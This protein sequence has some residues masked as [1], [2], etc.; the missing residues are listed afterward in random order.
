M[1]GSGEFVGRG[2]HGKGKLSRKTVRARACVRACSACNVCSV[3]FRKTIKKA[4][5]ASYALT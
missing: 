4:G 2:I 5:T 3:K 1:N